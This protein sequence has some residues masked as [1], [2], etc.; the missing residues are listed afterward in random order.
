MEIALSLEPKREKP[1]SAL[2]KKLPSAELNYA[3]MKH[4]Q[5]LTR[6]WASMIFSPV[7]RQ[8]NQQAQQASSSNFTGER[9]A[10][11]TAPVNETPANVFPCLTP[12][13]G[14]AVRTYARQPRSTLRAQIQM[15]RAVQHS[16]KA[17]RT[18]MRRATAQSNHTRPEI[19]AK[20]QPRGGHPLQPRGRV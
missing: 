7:L 8:Q 12:P 6:R 9:M 18:K 1:A 16:F 5:L 11:S 4:I 2:K 19:H 13:Q 20:P 10:R 15:P 3:N 17:S 14:S